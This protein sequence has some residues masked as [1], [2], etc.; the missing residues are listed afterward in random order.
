[1]AGVVYWTQWQV[2]VLKNPAFETGYLLF[3][4]LVFLAAYNLRKKLP[5]PLWINSA[6]WLQMHIYIGLSTSIVFGL[7]TGWRVPNGIFETTLALLYLATFA[8]GLVGIYWNRT[9]PRRLARASE[10]V[11]YER[12]PM[13]RSRL[14][15]RAEEVVLTTVRSAGVTTLGEFYNSQLKGYFESP[16]ER[17]YF[18]RPNSRLRKSLLAEL[19]EVSRYLSQPERESSEQLFALIRKR[20]D[21]DFHAA[22]Q[23]RLKMWLF[24]HIGLTYPLLAVASLHGLLT[25]LFDGGAL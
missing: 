19:T 25:H 20:D 15:E 14:R 10:E 8:S 13:L 5:I 9:L 11:I 21:L 7:H 2:S 3:A 24:V 1:L 23:W 4:A 12:I 16:R 17:R 6:D 18:L 22:L